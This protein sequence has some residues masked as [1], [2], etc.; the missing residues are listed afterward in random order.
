MT[1]LDK[2]VHDALYGYHPSHCHTSHKISS[3]NK[4]EEAYIY[5]RVL[6]G[7]RREEVSVKVED[8]ILSVNVN[9]PNA[10]EFAKAY[11]KLNLLGWLE[12]DADGSKTSAKLADGVLTVTVPRTKPV[13]NVHTVTVN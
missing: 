13:R 1:N 5:T 11:S 8:G 7:I 2:L 6:P 9:A 12:P 3:V 4:T 10:Q